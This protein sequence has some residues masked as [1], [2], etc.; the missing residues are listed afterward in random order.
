[1]LK[2]KNQFLVSELESVG[3]TA[4]E[5]RELRQ[6][7]LQR[8][9]GTIN[10]ILSVYSGKTEGVDLSNT[11]LG[12]SGTPGGSFFNLVLDNIDLSGVKLKSANLNQASLKGS[13]FRGVGED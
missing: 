10:K 13:R 7:R 2:N 9:Q 1:E 5:E 3:S 4:T 6:G 11:Q 12:Q 8:N